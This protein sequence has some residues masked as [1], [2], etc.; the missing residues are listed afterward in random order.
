[1]GIGYGQALTSAEAAV[2]TSAIGTGLTERIQLSCRIT[3]DGR[4]VIGLRGELDLATVDQMVRYVTDVID[5]HNGPVT[6]DLSGL[7]FCDACG[8]GALVRVAAHAERADRRLTLI[9]PSRA[10]TKIMRITGVDHLLLTPVAPV[11]LRVGAQGPAG[12]RD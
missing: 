7:A 11:V 5:R 6:A 2:W 1:M 9:R 12:G 8:L 4:A 3:A 10:L